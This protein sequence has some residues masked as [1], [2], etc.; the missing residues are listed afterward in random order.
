MSDL[1]AAVEF[2]ARLR[3]DFAAVADLL[4][5][6][7]AFYAFAGELAKAGMGADLDLETEKKF[8]RIIRAAYDEY[9][10]RKAKS[11]G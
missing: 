8:I 3:R 11:A 1:F 2:A 7:K 5:P 4:G 6:E 9:L 10:E